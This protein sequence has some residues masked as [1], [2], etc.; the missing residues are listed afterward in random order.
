MSSD[1]EDIDLNEDTASQLETITDDGN[2][3]MDIEGKKQNKNKNKES[4]PCFL[5]I[6]V[7]IYYTN[8]LFKDPLPSTQNSPAASPPQNLPNTRQVDLSINPQLLTCKSYDCVPLV[9]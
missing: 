1:E 4:P 3:L 2:D 9:K 6:N 5:Y 8:S 7:Y